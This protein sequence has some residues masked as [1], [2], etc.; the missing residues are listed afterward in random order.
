LE[1]IGIQERKGNASR[2]LRTSP[3]PVLHKTTEVHP[4]NPSA[5]HRRYSKI[6][7]NNP[8]RFRFQYSTPERL[9]NEIAIPVNLPMSMDYVR[10]LGSG[11]HI[12]V[13]SAGLLPVVPL[14]NRDSQSAHSKVFS[15]RDDLKVSVH[16][17]ANIEYTPDDWNV[18]VHS[19]TSLNPRPLDP[20]NTASIPFDS[21]YAA[22]YFVHDRAGIENRALAIFFFNSSR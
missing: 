6:V 20:S 7:Q 8:P 16:S 2:F 22:N 12:L 17:S 9:A 4:S 10:F 21:V 3:Q 18:L 1:T 13:P 5:S 11:R 19:K 15:K 14:G